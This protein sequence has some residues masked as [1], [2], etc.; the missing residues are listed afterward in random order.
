MWRVGGRELL[1]SS[2]ERK[3]QYGN[4]TCGE[5]SIDL[6][7]SKSFCMAEQQQAEISAI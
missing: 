4:L 3:G 7:A 1:Q 5:E 2:Y 6:T